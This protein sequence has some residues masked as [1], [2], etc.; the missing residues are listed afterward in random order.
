MR[1][2]T[3]LSFLINHVNISNKKRMYVNR[4]YAH[5]IITLDIAFPVVGGCI[6][7][8]PVYIILHGLNGGSRYFVWRCLSDNSMIAR[9]LINLPIRGWNTFH[10]AQRLEAMKR[11]IIIYV[12]HNYY[13][14]HICNT[15]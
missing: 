12:T 11:I 2:G 14:H 9:K 10:G 13:N 4:P 3:G 7:Y 15:L 1:C 5:E 6:L 8:E